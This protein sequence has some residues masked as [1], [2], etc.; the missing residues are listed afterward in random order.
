M[1]RRQF[2]RNDGLAVLYFFQF[3]G[4][5][6]SMRT[7]DL[8]HEELLEVDPEGCVIRVAGQRAFLIDA[9][10]MGLLGKYPVGKFGLTAARI[11]LT[12]LGFAHG[13]RMTGAMKAGFEWDTDEHW[14][15]AG[16]S[17]RAR[18]GLFRVEPGSKGFH[19][20]KGVTALASYEA[21]HF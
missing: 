16:T 3:E 6:Q 21:E 9:V 17:T 8:D 11:M 5:R 10:A 12:R 2:L 7:D 19:S 13:W 20:K 18:E 15:R 14:R 4:E 1:R